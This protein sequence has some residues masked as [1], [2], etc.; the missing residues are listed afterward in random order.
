MVEI[1]KALSRQ[2]RL[3]ILDEGT[4]A[5]TIREVKLVFQVME[6]MRQQNRSVIFISHRMD[7]IEEIA[8]TIT[9][10]RDGQDVGV[11]HAGTVSHDELVQRM[12]GRKLEQVF[13]EKSPR[14]P[15]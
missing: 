3:L 9:I 7:E 11:F 15:E 10:F 1:A 12:I 4:S 2:P 6:Q 5:L 13:P 14:P 8:D